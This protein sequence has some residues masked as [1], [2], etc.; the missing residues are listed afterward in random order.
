MAPNTKGIFISYRR[1]GNA[2]YAGRLAD[3]LSEHFG[4]HMV[5]RDIDSIEPGLD[6]AEAIER[7]VGSSEV[8]IA[9]IGRS[10]LTAT[11]TT[12]RERLQNP[13][14][15]VR[16]EIVTALRRNIRVIPVLVEGASMPSVDELPGD[17]A[18]LTRRHAFELHESSWREGV[19]RLV[20][21]LEKVVGPSGPVT[22]TL[23]SP[24]GNVSTP[25]PTVQATVKAERGN[26]SERDLR[27]YLDDA[28]VRRFSYDPATGQLNYRPTGRL[29]AG[30][31]TVEI[32]VTYKQE[33]RTMVQETRWGF[34]V[35]GFTVES[36]EK[37]A[38]RLPLWRRIFGG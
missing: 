38:E 6:F 36:G 35:E 13:D 24:R 23:T 22:I 5:F 7:A 14:D 2:A 27:L 15:Y 21:R 12:G 1:A 28:E 9:V 29:S 3:K 26:V 4:E 25:V 10:W 33:D 11:D 32:R 37:G 20:T 18:P 30:T 17:L 8:L 19:Q 34:T 31:H 16:M